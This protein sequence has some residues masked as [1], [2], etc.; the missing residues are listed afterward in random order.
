MGD[1]DNPRQ[2]WNGMCDNPR[3]APV[4][5]PV[6]EPSWGTGGGTTS[7]QAGGRTSRATAAVPPVFRVSCSDPHNSSWQE[8]TTTG[9]GPSH[10]ARTNHAAGHYASTGGDGGRT[11]YASSG[12]DGGRT[13]TGGDERGRWEGPR[14]EVGGEVGEVLVRR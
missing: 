14:K 8:P 11:S 3:Y 2:Q 13:S 9:P 10:G 12:G 1:H 5:F 4:N 6:G 7:S